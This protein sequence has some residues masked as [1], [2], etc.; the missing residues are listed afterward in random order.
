VIVQVGGEIPLARSGH[1]AVTYKR[2]IYMF[3]VHFSLGSWFKCRSE[4]DSNVFVVFFLSTGGYDMMS[5]LPHM[6]AFDL[7]TLMFDFELMH[8]VRFFFH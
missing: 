8:H 4:T 5:V 6:F 7:G 2:Q 1:V 3:G